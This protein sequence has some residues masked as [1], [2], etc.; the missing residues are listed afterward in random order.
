MTPRQLAQEV[1][2][3]F[4]FRSRDAM[5]RF[6]AELTAL[7]TPP[8]LGRLT[9]EQLEQRRSDLRVLLVDINDRL[10]AMHAAGRRSAHL[11]ALLD[12]PSPF[13]SLDPSDPA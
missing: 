1:E 6:L 8:D 3:A 9:R 7:A 4:D 11:R 5:V 13:T 10:E 2:N 12:P